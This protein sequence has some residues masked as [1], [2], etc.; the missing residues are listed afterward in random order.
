MAYASVNVFTVHAG[1]MDAFITLQRQAL[2]PLLHQQPGFVAMEIVRTGE[3]TGVATLWWVSEDARRAATP[4]LN[5]WVDEYL[6]PF[7]VT[8]DNPAGE[9]VL[10]SRDTASSSAGT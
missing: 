6:E 1:Q 4:G 3:D 10:T 8:L 7:F 2:L 9:V 5:A